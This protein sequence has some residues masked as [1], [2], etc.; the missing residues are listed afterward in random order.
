MGRGR[1][2]GLQA[3]AEEDRELCD[4]LCSTP[5]ASTATACRPGRKASAPTSQTS[6]RRSSGGTQEFVSVKE[7]IIVSMEDLERLPETSFEK[8]GW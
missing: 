6:S 3:L 1:N 7:Q 5:S 8:N 2:A 4:I